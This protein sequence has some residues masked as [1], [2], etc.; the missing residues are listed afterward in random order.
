MDRNFKILNRSKNSKIKKA[1]FLKIQPKNRKP[2]KILKSL[3]KP[4]NNSH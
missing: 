4:S 2:Y 1:I 3:L